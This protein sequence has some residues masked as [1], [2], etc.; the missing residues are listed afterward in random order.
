MNSKKTSTSGPAN[1]VDDATT[2]GK[3]LFA[4]KLSCSSD[5]RPRSVPNIPKTVTDDLMAHLREFKINQRPYSDTR[6]KTRF[7]LNVCAPLPFACLTRSPT[8]IK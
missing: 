4:Y 7:T 1:K 6:L 3:Y 2:G 8:C 5:W